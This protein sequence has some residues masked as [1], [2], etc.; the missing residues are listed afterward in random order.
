MVFFKF[1][2]WQFWNIWN[3]SSPAPCTDILCGGSDRKNRKP[4]AYYALAKIFKNI[5]PGT[6]FV[7][8]LTSDL[9][10]LTLTNAV[11]MNGGAFV[12]ANKTVVVLVNSTSDDTSTSLH[13][14]Y[15]KKAEVFQID[16]SN[17]ELFDTDMT[18]INTPNITNGMID[19]ITLSRNT[20]TVV[21]SDGG[22]GKNIQSNLAK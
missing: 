2:Y 5:A 1:N 13:G 4:A 7:R 10:G 15:G 9:P 14:V 19:R 8:R 16:G 3:I 6:T 12:S 20:I 17:N 21:V 22:Y 18:L 11:A